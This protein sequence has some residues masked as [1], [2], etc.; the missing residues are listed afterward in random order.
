[1]V[2]PDAVS[3]AEP[4]A[5]NA[6]SFDM[7]SGGEG[8]TVTVTESKAKQPKEFVPVTVYVVVTEGLAVGFAVFAPTSEDEGDQ[9]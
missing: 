7:V 5:Q 2:E 4:P 6:V 8:V 1:V 3:V 9:E